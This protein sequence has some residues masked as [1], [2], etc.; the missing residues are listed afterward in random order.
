VRI[1]APSPAPRHL[2]TQISCIADILHVHSEGATVQG[3]PLRHYPLPVTCAHK[4]F[5]AHNLCEH[6]EGATVHSQV[7]IPFTCA[8][9]LTQ[10]NSCL[11]PLPKNKLQNKLSQT[12]HVKY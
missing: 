4:K 6:G 10:I 2:S 3:A 5:S 9:L 12:I 1:R 7:S 8:P 11:L